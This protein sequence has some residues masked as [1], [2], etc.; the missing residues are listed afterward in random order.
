MI[1]YIHV[2]K[3]TI[4]RQKKPRCMFFDD[5]NLNCKRIGE[6]AFKDF[7]FFKKNLDD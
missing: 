5:V 7:K 2:N 6:Y 1:W 4:N 3:E